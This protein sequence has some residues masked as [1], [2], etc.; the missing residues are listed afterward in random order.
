MGGDVPV[1]PTNTRT[2]TPNC[3]FERIISDPVVLCTV[4]AMPCHCARWA[5]VSV[6]HLTMR[7]KSLPR[8]HGL[9]EL[10]I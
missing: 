9:T 6:V 1:P 8:P 2:E 7:E 4:R 10:R 5:A 3:S